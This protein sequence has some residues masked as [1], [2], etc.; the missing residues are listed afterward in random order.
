MNI[1]KKFL[2][3][4]NSSDDDTDN[5]A[6]CIIVNNKG[7]ILLVRRANNHPGGGQWDLP[8]GHIHEKEK[9]ED[10]A[11]REAFEESGLH[12][13]DKLEK[14]TSVKIL[15]PENGVKSTMHIFKGT[16]SGM[17]QVTL[18]PTTNNVDKH[19]WQHF[20]KPEHTEYKWVKYKDEL[21]R[22]P[23]LKQLKDVVIKHL[24]T[25]RAY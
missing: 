23:M 10:A 16:I 24:K 5:S 13:D 4:A 22:I 1:I 14:I 25:R 8:G 2:I 6:K 20:G 18:A 7:Y 11:R 19:H 15:I 12:L 21:E 3:E 9:H 17:D